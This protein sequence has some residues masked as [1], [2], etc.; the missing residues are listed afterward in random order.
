MKTLMIYFL[1][2]SFVLFIC[3]HFT[4]Q[5]T[6]ELGFMMLGKLLENYVSQ[7]GLNKGSAFWNLLK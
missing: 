2:L 6:E 3:V 7:S 1:I 5:L 4:F